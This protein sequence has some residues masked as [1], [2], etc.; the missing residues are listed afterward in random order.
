MPPM[1]GFDDYSPWTDGT[2]TILRL[3]KVACKFV[4]SLHGKY[5]QRYNKSE[6]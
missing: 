5:T 3:D 2:V 4:V 1:N 6:Y